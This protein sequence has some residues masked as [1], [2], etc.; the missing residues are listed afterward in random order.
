MQHSPQIKFSARRQQSWQEHDDDD[1][2]ADYDDYYADYDDEDDDYDIKY[3]D[4][5]CQDNYDK[6]LK[7]MR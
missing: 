1:G 7:I 2:Y 3:D 6:A 4:A 5:Q